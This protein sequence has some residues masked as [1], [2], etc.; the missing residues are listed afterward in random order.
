MIPAGA[1]NNGVVAYTGDVTTNTLWGFGVVQNVDAA[2]MQ[3]YAGYRN[4]G[5]ASQ[6][7]TVAGGCS[8]ITVIMA[9]GVVKF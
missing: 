5:L 3:V 2:A 4:Y 7:C 8:N 9:G 1:A 6:N